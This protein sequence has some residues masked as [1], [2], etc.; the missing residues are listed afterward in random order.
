M[1]PEAR[2]EAP[3]VTRYAKHQLNYLRDLSWHQTVG[4]A[5][6]WLT[7]HAGDDETRAAVSAFL[8]RRR[9][10]EQPMS[11]EIVL[12]ERRGAVGLITMNR[13]KQLNAL[14]D[15][16]MAALGDALT[17][18]DGDDAIRVAVVT[19]S[20]PGVRRRRGHRRDGRRHADRHP[21]RPAARS[22]GSGCAASRSR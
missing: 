15:E 2:G 19:G 22:A 16:L 7:L 17:E 4:H 3:E 14:S 8:E 11:D 12:L 9:S 18:L 13:P 10:K 1:G 5:R 6:D 20:R 21:H